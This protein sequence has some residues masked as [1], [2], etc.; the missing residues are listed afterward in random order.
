VLLKIG[1]RPGEKWVGKTEA[2]SAAIERKYGIV[3]G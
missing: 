1:A 2:E 3:Y